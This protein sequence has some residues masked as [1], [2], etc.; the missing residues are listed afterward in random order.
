MKKIS[1]ML[2]SVGIM[3]I[4]AGC[5]SDVI[6]EGPAE[7]TGAIAF[8][9]TNVSKDSRA[10]LAYGESMTS[11]NLTEFYVY[12]YY[13]SNEGKKI[14]VFTGEKT[15]KGTGDKWTY[16]GGLRYWVPGLKYKFYAFSCGNTA[17]LAQETQRPK[18]ATFGDN[19]LKFNE[20]S[21]HNHDL[22]L[23]ESEEETRAANE[24][25]AVHL[26]FKHILT[27][28]KFSFNCETPSDDYV[29]ELSNVKLQ[30][31]Y[32]KA[33]YNGTSWEKHEGTNT[34]EELVIDGSSIVIPSEEGK[35]LACKPVFVIPNKYAN[36]D[37][38]VKLLFTMTIK[39]QNET[40]LSRNVEA[41]WIPNWMQGYSMNNIVK[42]KFQDATGLK[43]IEFTAEVVKGDN[44]EEDG[45]TESEG[46]L[47]DITFTPQATP[48]N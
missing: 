1:T 36:K 42:I 20:Y 13:T 9:T 44:N 22:I 29:I 45:W 21:C 5:S 34:N 16:E 27:R 28:L 8:G 43:P 11:S 12:G 25:Q 38:A 35:A 39:Y 24:T 26:K 3:A 18:Y 15:T 30:G 2:L 10:A 37:N 4:A 40:I 32:E 31:H 7:H 46:G 14:N 41:T 6:D 33:D 19:G 47:T 48:G 17:D 23:A